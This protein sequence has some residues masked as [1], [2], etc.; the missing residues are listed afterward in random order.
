MRFGTYVGSNIVNTRWDK[1]LFHSFFSM[2]QKN[3]QSCQHTRKRQTKLQNR[4]Q[5]KDILYT[6]TFPLPSVVGLSIEMAISTIEAPL[7]SDTVDG[8]VD[9]K[10][11]PVLRSTFGSWRS[12]SFIIGN[13]RTVVPNLTHKQ[14]TEMR[15]FFFVSLTN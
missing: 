3:F 7:L 10:G 14:M 9:Y 11:R 1:K 12:A 5:G 8:A 4:G 13:T 6:K 15:D 2:G